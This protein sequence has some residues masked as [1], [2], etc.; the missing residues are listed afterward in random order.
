M[1]H[2]RSPALGLTSPYMHFS[3]LPPPVGQALHLSQSPVPLLLLA[4]QEQWFWK[5]LPMEMHFVPDGPSIRSFLPLQD[6]PYLWPSLT[7]YHKQVPNHYDNQNTPP[8]PQFQTPP[9]DATPPLVEK[10]FQHP[11]ALCP[12]KYAS[13]A[14]HCVIARS[15]K[16]RK[17]LSKESEQEYTVFK[18]VHAPGF[19][20][21]LGSLS[22]S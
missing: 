10:L 18:R 6:V 21:K 7:K 13:E 19:S 11:V 15:H 3:R 14:C 4:V 2:S 20:E 1:S 16:G 8:L 9:L 5:S 12:W 22:L 17:Q